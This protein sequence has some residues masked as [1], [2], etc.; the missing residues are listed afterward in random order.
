MI[1]IEIGYLVVYNDGLFTLYLKLN[2][3]IAFSFANF[4]IRVSKIKG[5]FNLSKWINAKNCQS[6][7]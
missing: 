1:L 2:F 5:V 6:K 3:T 4:W 7:P